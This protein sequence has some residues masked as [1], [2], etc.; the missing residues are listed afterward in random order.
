MSNDYPI[1]IINFNFENRFYTFEEQ[2]AYDEF[3]L[4][5]FDFLVNPDIPTLEYPKIYDRRIN[6]RDSKH[7]FLLNL[8]YH[9]YLA[10]YS[11]DNKLVRKLYLGR[12]NMPSDVPRFTGYVDF[13][14]HDNKIVLIRKTLTPGT[15]GLYLIDSATLKDLQWNLFPKIK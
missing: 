12:S 1:Y 15:Y 3:D 14:S 5:S 6:S 2:S 11:S 9:R 4:N 8:G 10:V 7:Y 13:W